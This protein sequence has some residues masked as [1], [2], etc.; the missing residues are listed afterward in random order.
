MSNY[1]EA[2]MSHRVPS[3]SELK[4]YFRK[5]SRRLGVSSKKLSSTASCFH[6]LI[7]FAVHSI[8]YPDGEASKRRF[9]EF[10]ESLGMSSEALKAIWDLK[11]P[12]RENPFPL[13]PIAIS[14]TAGMIPD[15]I[16]MFRQNKKK[17]S[18]ENKGGEV[19]G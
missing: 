13:V 19:S 3:V 17:S 4:G 10:A 15:I 5:Y 8:G 2:L 1:S 9:G 16:R 14:L 18:S 6:K 12:A 7:E 11:E